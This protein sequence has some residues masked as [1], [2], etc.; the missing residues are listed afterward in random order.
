M[1]KPASLEPTAKFRCPL[2]GQSDGTLIVDAGGA[3]VQAQS[4]VGCGTVYQAAPPSV[5]EL[6]HAYDE[7]Y[8]LRAH[9]LQLPMQ[10]GLLDS[11]DP[12]FEAVKQKLYASRASN[13]MTLCYMQ[14]EDRVLELGC[15]DGRSLLHQRELLGVHVFGADPCSEARDAA[16]ELG[17][18]VEPT[19][20]DQ[21]QWTTADLDHVQAF[22]FL[23]R[24]PSP[25]AWLTHC[26][27]SLKVGGRV[28][29]EVPN[30]YHPN[31]PLHAH[32]LRPAHL[33]AWSESTLVALMRRS[34]FAVERVVS[35]LTLFV[36]GR[37]VSDER[38][39]TRFT[40]SML[41]HPHH[42]HTWVS[43]RL[44]TYAAMEDTKATMLRDGPNM[45]TIHRFVHLLMRPALPCHV[46]DVTLDLVSF[47]L[48]HQAVGLAC[49]IATAASQGPYEGPL[50]R[51]MAKLA[52]VLRAEGAAAVGLSPAVS[53]AADQRLAR[54]TLERDALA[55]AST[56]PSAALSAVELLMNE[57]RGE[58]HNRS[59]LQL[60]TPTP[61][62]PISGVVAQA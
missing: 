28:L 24:V 19:P 55:P 14:P 38:N 37:K 59:D 15:T 9:Q 31:G 41:T 22:H 27:N 29:V 34:G 54:K 10:P 7:E 51:R 62:Y 3:E 2:C 53:P 13:A 36:V 4:C 52:G 8:A 21:P 58:F 12:Q 57:I 33:H 46:V 26:W 61:F 17:I 47:F 18:A 5:A 56:P 11:S 44:A 45:D 49:L 1:P 42:D 39:A 23:Q 48:S 43:T 50:K 25:H 32:L 6:S 16:K 40:P 30:L 20:L 60:P 35:T